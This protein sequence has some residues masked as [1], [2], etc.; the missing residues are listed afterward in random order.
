MANGLVFLGATKGN[1]FR[2]AAPGLTAISTLALKE[3]QLPG[4]WTLG[5]STQRSHATISASNSVTL[6][7]S[8]RLPHTRAGG[9][10]H[11]PPCGTPFEAP[12]AGKNQHTSRSQCRHQAQLLQRW[13]PLESL[14]R[15]N[16]FRKISRWEMPWDCSFS[17]RRGPSFLRRWAS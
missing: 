5:R 16:A 14:R 17:V 8:A 2:E 4:F 9:E 15:Q 3:T 7:A 11:L 13:I 10:N 12:D 6:S 1:T